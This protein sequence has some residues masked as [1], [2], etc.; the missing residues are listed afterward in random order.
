MEALRICVK[1]ENGVLTIKLPGKLAES[2][3]LEIIILP[4]E[5][6]QKA[7]EKK[8]KPS[9]YFGIWKNK[10]IDPDIVGKEL[11]NEWDRGF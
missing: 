6:E 5:K 3:E 11:R 8:F 2:K 1:P 9:E 4:M 7:V 10:N